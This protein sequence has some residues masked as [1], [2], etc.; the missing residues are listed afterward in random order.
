MSSSKTSLLREVVDREL[1]D[2]QHDPLD[3]IVHLVRV[4]QHGTWAE[5]AMAIHQRIDRLVT[6]Q[7]LINWYPQYRGS[8][9][10][11]EAS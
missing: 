7:T 5:V 4:D 11:A 1:A 2:G 8:L 3:Q 9:A 6:Q 10:E